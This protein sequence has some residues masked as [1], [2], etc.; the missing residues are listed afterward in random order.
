LSKGQ[1]PA[2]PEQ[3]TQTNFF[4]I[5]ASIGIKIKAIDE[6]KT[7]IFAFKKDYRPSVIDDIGIQPDLKSL[8]EVFPFTIT[9]DRMDWTTSSIDK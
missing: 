2:L 8:R 4:K 1:H 3:L 9:R 6:I 7:S 5:N